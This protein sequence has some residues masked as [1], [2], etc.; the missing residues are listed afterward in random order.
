MNNVA[1]IKF[2]VC[3]KSICILLQLSEN[4]QVNMSY[5]DSLVIT[6]IWC[7]LYVQGIRARLQKQTCFQQSQKLPIFFDYNPAY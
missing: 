4:C 2:T 6:W 5:N 3:E 1:S 7:V